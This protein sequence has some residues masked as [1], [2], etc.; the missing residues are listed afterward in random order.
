M[1]G[2]WLLIGVAVAGAGLAV[3]VFRPDLLP[4]GA[5]SLPDGCDEHE[6]KS[7]EIKQGIKLWPCSE[8]LDRGVEYE[9]NTGHCGLGFATDFDG[10]FWT[11]EQDA[12]PPDAY[13]N[14]DTGTI[15]VVDD[16]TAIYR[17]DD[18]YDVTLTRHEGPYIEEE[19]CA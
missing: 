8:P 18:G 11:P 1:S 9:F 6:W 4:W 17:S 10:S 3:A 19:G 13:I 5:R 2:R 7:V 16:D 15:E 14:E 12:R